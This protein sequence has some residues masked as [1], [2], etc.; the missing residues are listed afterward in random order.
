MTLGHF[1]KPAPLNSAGRDT[2]KPPFL[3]ID[4]DDKFPSPE[5]S[6]NNIEANKLLAKTPDYNRSIRSS[7]YM[8]ATNNRSSKRSK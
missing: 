2:S 1:L 7:V 5:S 8:S 4:S 3:T 6:L